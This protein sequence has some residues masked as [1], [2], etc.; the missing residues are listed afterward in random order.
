MWVLVWIH[1]LNGNMEH[2]QLGTFPTEDACYDQKAEAKV[3]RKHQNSGLFCLF[4]RYNKLGQYVVY[5]KFGKVVIITHHKR[6]AERYA[7]DIR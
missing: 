1:L 6:I 3:L 5:D 4:V 7:D 2:Y